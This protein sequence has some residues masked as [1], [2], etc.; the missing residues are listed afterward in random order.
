MEVKGEN[1]VLMFGRKGVNAM[2]IEIDTFSKTVLT[3]DRISLKEVGRG[4]H[5]VKLTLVNNLRNLM[6]PHHIG[7]GESYAVGPGSFYKE[8]CVWN[9][10]GC[11]DN[12][13]EDYCF[14]EFGVE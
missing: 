5:K 13:N 11:S 2:R 9:P 6:G 1:P 12:W 8:K 4:R 14:V 10:R 7:E 3:E